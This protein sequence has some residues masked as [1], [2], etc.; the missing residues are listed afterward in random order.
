MPLLLGR[1]VVRGWTHPTAFSFVN[2]APCPAP[3]FCRRISKAKKTNH[4]S[5]LVL[6]LPKQVCRRD[7]VTTLFAGIK[8]KMARWPEIQELSRNREQMSFS[9]PHIIFSGLCTWDY[10]HQSPW[11]TWPQF[12]AAAESPL[13]QRAREEFSLCH[14]YKIRKAF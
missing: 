2:S 1:E 7:S 13:E 14:S 8:A 4:I 10:Q 12:Q 9:R 3:P 5:P 6:V 11:A